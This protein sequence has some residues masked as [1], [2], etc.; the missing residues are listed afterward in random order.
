MNQRNTSLDFL[1]VIATLAV[2]WL[3]VSAVV[4][5]SNPDVHSIT[6]WTGNIADAFSR[7]CVPVFVMI[8]GALLFSASANPTP[9]E[10]Y[11]KRTRRLLPPIVFWTL[12][13]VVFREYTESTFSLKTAATSIIKGA[14]YYH[15]WYLYMVVGLYF[16]TPFLRPLV[17]GIHSDSLRLLIAGCFTISAIESALGHTSTTFLPRFLPFIG[18]FLAGY[19]LLSHP[20]NLSS[21]LLVSIFLVCGVFIAIGTGTLFPLLGPKSW[22]IMYSYLNP[23]V[24]VM[25][26]CIF[27]LFAKKEVALSITLGLFQRIAPIALGVYLVHPFWLWFL[28]KFGVTGFLM[29]PLVGIPIT[30]L[31]AFTLSVVSAAL[32]ANIP[33]LRRTVCSTIPLTMRSTRTRLERRASELER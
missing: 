1:R 5:V 27:L 13:Y 21:R 11:K 31:L 30:T 26:L 10:F 17:S 19:Y 12:I 18:Y 9:I 29:H 23:I 4:V 16:V 24:I 7:W 3:H 20:N 6:W 15:L 2:V 32:L 22:D 8:S 14:P 33:I 28:S 25:S